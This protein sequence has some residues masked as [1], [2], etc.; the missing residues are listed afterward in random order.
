ME[1]LLIEEEKNKIPKKKVSIRAIIGITILLIVGVI[2]FELFINH[3][4]S[5][6]DKNL[7]MDKYGEAKQYYQI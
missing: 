1:E 4:I 3:F 7:N 2:G 5:E 6:A